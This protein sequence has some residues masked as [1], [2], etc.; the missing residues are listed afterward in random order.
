MPPT[1]SSKEELPQN[2]LCEFTFV[3]GETAVLP[4]YSV[5]SASWYAVELDDLLYWEVLSIKQGTNT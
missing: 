1:P 2:V 4:F 5:Q 3:D